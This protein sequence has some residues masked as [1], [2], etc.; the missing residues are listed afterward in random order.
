M[1]REIFSGYQEFITKVVKHIKIKS[2][3]LED[4]NKFGLIRNDRNLFH[5][6]FT[7]TECFKIS[8]T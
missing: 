5:R 2:N 6:G 1:Y 3:N 8:A 4:D 7:Y